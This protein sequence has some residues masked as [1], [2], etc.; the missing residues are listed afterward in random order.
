MIL[1]SIQNL[2]KELKV[3]FLTLI[4][5]KMELLN[6]YFDRLVFVKIEQKENFT[7]Y[8][9]AI[10]SSFGD[11]KKTYALAF[12]PAHLAI[13]DKGFLK[14]L[15]W[16]NFQTRTLTNGWKIPGQRWDMRQL[17]GLPTPMFD[18]VERNESKTKYRCETEPLEMVLLH[19]PKKKSVYQYHNRINLLA[20]LATFKCVLNFV[21]GHEMQAT[22]STEPLPHQQ[23]L[24]GPQRHLDMSAVPITSLAVRMPQQSP[25]YKSSE[26]PEDTSYVPR[27]EG[28]RYAAN[29]ANT[30]EGAYEFNN[31]T[32]VGNT[33]YRNLSLDISVPDAPRGERD[34]EEYQEQPARRAVRAPTRGQRNEVSSR[35]RKQV[36]Q[37]EFQQR[38]QIDDSFELL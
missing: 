36:H 9:A 8:A 25:V 10:S 3:S 19:D 20:A 38:E 21:E 13:L 18:A 24:Q 15:H 6:A 12:V 35:G 27:N 30:A 7:I 28:T 4:V 26:L 23:A 17:K 34:E 1:Q 11:G 5:R 37:P 31:T 32:V 16:Q 2:S 29:S 22:R 14:D 33:G